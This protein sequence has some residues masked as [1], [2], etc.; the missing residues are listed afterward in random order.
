M[1]QRGGQGVGRIFTHRQ[2]ER[3]RVFAA[4]ERE[5]SFLYL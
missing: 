3:L 5:D 2:P 4:K 1:T